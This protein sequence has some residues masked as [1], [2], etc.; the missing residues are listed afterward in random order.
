MD[1][2]VSI[3]AWLGLGVL[4]LGVTGRLLWAWRAAR[5]EGSVLPVMSAR[6][7]L[8]SLWHWLVPLSTRN[9]RLHPLMT[10]VSYGFHLCLLLAPLLAAGHVEL[11]RQRWG[12][13]WPTLPAP[14]IDVMTLVV[15]GAV[16]FF[17]L[18]RLV[19]PEVRNVTGWREYL[20]LLVVVAPFITGIIAHLQ[21]LDYRLVMVL[22]IVS[23][24]LWLVLIP[25][26][27]LSHMFWFFFTRSY[28][29]SEFGAVRN[30]RDW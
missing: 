19:A 8:R 9:Q 18:R 2:L 23:G 5:G 3:A 13:G 17:L 7:G 24:T 22:H 25:F 30:A 10:L 14:V 4:L 1:L 6:Y 29:G 16:V 11:W 12:F 27:W 21:L 15:I 28:M 20:L 26:S